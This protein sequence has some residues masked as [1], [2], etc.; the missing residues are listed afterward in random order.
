VASL[1]DRGPIGQFAIE[2]VA[3]VEKTAELQMQPPRIGA[4]PPGHPPDGTDPGDALDRLDAET[5]ML[6]LD[7]FSDRLVVEPAIARLT[8]SCPSSTKASELGVALGRLGERQ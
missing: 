4:R 8:I 7:L 1:T 2:R 3:V 5:D 6:A